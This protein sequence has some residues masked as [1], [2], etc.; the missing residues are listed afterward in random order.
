MA[1]QKSER[2]HRRWGQHARGICAGHCPVVARVADKSTGWLASPQRQV[3]AK[4]EP[5]GGAMFG[6]QA[7]MG[8]H[9]AWMNA[10]RLVGPGPGQRAITNGDERM[11]AAAAI[12]GGSVCDVST[13][14]PSSAPGTP[15]TLAVCDTDP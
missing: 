15:A 3:A 5:D 8:R 2:E 6:Y 12:K 7:I 14:A 13:A 9:N 10:A 4:R 1:A 11:P